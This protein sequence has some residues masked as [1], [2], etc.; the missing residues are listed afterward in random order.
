MGAHALTGWTPSHN[1]TS[2]IL[3]SAGAHCKRFGVDPVF[4][5]FAAK[6]DVRTWV[7]MRDFEG[8]LLIGA[9]ERNQTAARNY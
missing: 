4:I 3:A 1:E 7:G 5:L 2:Q 8:V 6:A 9:Q